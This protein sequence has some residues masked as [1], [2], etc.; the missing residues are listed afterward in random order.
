[1][2]FIQ[3]RQDE[4]GVDGGGRRAG[5]M[6]QECKMQHAKSTGAASP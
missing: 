6:Q 2:A 1:M 5:Y 3:D 4:A